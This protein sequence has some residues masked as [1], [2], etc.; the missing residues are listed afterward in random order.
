MD[1]KRNHDHDPP[2]VLGLSEL[3]EAP[4]IRLEMRA[5]DR[6]EAIEALVDL[7]IAKRRIAREDRSNIL[8]ALF[9]REGRR[10]STLKNGVA[11][12][13]CA[14]DRALTANGPSA[15][16]ALLAVGR[17]AEGVDFRASDG[18]P[19]TLIFLILL[20]RAKFARF[21]EGLPLLARLFE[22]GALTR[23]LM[24]VDSAE[25]FIEAIERTESWEYAMDAVESRDTP[26]GGRVGG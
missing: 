10:P 1:A 18:L 7:L 19:V 23:T 6:W 4:L 16:R 26:A 9:D 21:A 11:A 5:G 8:A 22:T 24:A 2:E 20:P 17:C 12:P 15:P 25:A 13:A 3:V 14:Y